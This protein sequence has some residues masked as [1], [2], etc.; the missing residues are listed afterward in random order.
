MTAASRYLVIILVVLGILA[1]AAG[2]IYFVEPAKSLPAFFPGHSTHLKG[3]RTTRG[4]AG[5]IAGAVLLIIAVIVARTGRRPS[6]R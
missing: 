1:V 3:R 5:F 6:Y 4:L 2:I